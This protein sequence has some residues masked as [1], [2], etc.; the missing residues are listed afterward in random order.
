MRPHLILDFSR[1]YPDQGFPQAL[2]GEG[3]V[4]ELLD[5]AGIEGTR[6]YCDDAAAAEIRRR[7]SPYEGIPGVHWLDSGDYHYMTLFFASVFEDPFTLVLLDNHPDDREAEFPGVLS[8]G[9][10]VKTLRETCPG[11]VRTVSI[12]PDGARPALPQP[13]GDV[14]LSI[15]QDI[16]TPACSRT[17]WSQGDF[18]L[19]E[20]EGIVTEVFDRASRVL[21]VDICG[22][23]STDH[24]AGPED[25]R[26]NLETNL[27]LMN[28]IN[29]LYE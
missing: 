10:W 13:L 8:C 29:R 21:G 15:D 2:E 28:L 16:L 27:Y 11:L 7:I 3:V 24:G 6:C 12:G 20:V 14:Y 4:F 9:S 26:I 23:L 1:A 17:D 22:E 19:S 18:P 25:R 5:M